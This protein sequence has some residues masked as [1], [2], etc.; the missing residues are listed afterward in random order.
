MEVLG[1]LLL[2]VLIAYILDLLFGDPYWFPHPVRFIG[3]LIKSTEKCLRRLVEFLVVRGVENKGK[4]ERVAGAFLMLIVTGVVF[5]LLL[6]ILKAALLVHPVL[7]HILNIYILY[8]SF[9][10][11]CLADEAKK[12]QACLVKGSLEDSRKQLAMLVG[13]QTEHLGEKEIIRGVVETTAENTV[14]G[15]VSPLLYALLGS[16]FGIGAPLVY[17]FKAISTLDSMVGYMNEKYINFGRVSA[18]TDDAVNYLPARLTGLLIPAAAFLCGQSFSGSLRIMLRDRRN[19]KSPNCAYPEAAV[20]GAL[21]VQLGGANVY[22]GQVM[23]KPTI[24]DAKR[25]LKAADIQ[26][27]VR[28]MYVTSLIIV[29]LGALISAAVL[30]GQGMG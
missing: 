16:F 12:V 30:A 1:Y 5:V 2:D 21:G 11:K 28:I 27:T 15:V 20:A 6:G 3:W 7:F 22:F 10:A 8:S 23:E 29:V 4:A 26:H 9:A 14:D 13:R 17:A 18:K 24:G 19:H 25:E